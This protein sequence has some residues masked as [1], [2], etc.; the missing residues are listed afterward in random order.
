[1][2]TRPYD[3]Y[4]SLKST[5]INMRRVAYEFMEW[6]GRSWRWESGNGISV[7]DGFFSM[8]WDLSRDGAQPGTYWTDQGT[9]DE[10]T[11]LL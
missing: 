3:V 10:L 6:I 8:H 2:R 1:M 7:S 4:L 11:N 9:Q 5:D